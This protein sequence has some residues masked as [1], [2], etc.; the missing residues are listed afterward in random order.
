VPAAEKIFPGKTDEE[1]EKKKLYAIN[2]FFDDELV[3][4]LPTRKEV[5]KA[6][7]SDLKARNATGYFKEKS[8]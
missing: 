1:V 7:F 6:L 8:C 4:Q 2:I 5:L 3:E